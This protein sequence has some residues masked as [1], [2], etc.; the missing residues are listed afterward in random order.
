MYIHCLEY[1][2]FYDYS[3]S[4]PEG[5]GEQ[6]SDSEVSPVIGGDQWPLQHVLVLFLC[7]IEE[8]EDLLCG[9]LLYS[10]LFHSK[11][12][13]KNHWVF[14]FSFTT[15]YLCEAP[16]GSRIGGE[17][18]I[19]SIPVRIS[20][21]LCTKQ[22]QQNFTSGKTALFLL[23]YWRK[24]KI[25]PNLAMPSPIPIY[26]LVHSCRIILLNAKMCVRVFIYVYPI[27][28]ELE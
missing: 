10:F 7:I 28:G 6:E 16:F 24:P 21:S 26:W 8:R 9:N 27:L 1:A 19:F 3:T 25:S 11:I 13:A 23:R 20:L 22:Q 12:D 18:K 5:E 15:I 17:L 14:F 4:Y 2:D